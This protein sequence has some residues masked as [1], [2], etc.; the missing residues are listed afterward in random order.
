MVC[1]LSQDQV[2]ADKQFE[3]ELVSSGLVVLLLSVM[4]YL[5]TSALLGPSSAEN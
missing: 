5:I 3:A 4:C 1:L 2:L